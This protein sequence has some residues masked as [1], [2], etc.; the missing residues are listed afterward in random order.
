MGDFTNNGIVMVFQIKQFPELR[1]VTSGVQRVSLHIIVAHF[2][3]S[4]IF[5]LIYWLDFFLLFGCVLFHIRINILILLF[6]VLRYL[7]YLQFHLLTNGIFD[8]IFETI[9]DLSDFGEQN[10]SSQNHFWLAMDYHLKKS[11]N[12]CSYS[13]K[14]IVLLCNIKYKIKNMLTGFALKSF[15]IIDVFIK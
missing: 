15:W 9:L 2:N 11:F 14:R 10:Q 3:I 12:K 7:I 5:I 1:L 4:R 6:R 8:H 13:F